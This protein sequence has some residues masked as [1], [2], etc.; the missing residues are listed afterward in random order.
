VIRDSTLA[1]SGVPAVAAAIVTRDSV[2]ALHVAGVRRRGNPTPVTLDDR[3]HIGSNTKAFTA[4][5]MGLLVDEGRVAWATTLA[6]LFPELAATM[7]PEYR[8]VTVRDLLTH[9]GGLVRDARDAPENEPGRAAAA[10]A[11]GDHQ[12][13]LRPAREPRQGRPAGGARAPSPFARVTAMDIDNPPLADPAGRLNLSIREWARWAQAVLR[14]AS[15]G[16]SPWTPTTT[17]ALF[18]P[19]VAT[20]S[21]AMGWQALRRPWAQPGGRILVHDGSN[22][23]FLSVAVLAPE[24]G[25]AVLVV[26]NQGGSGG[27]KVIPGLANRLI[28]LV[29]NGQQLH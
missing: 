25:F 21:M 8:A 18:T 6:E 10:R 27:D 2:V 23:L 14:A 29:T 7:R 13:R 16:A 28:R 22:R 26:T 1:A 3:F 15:G 11:A 9:H 5:L 24:A 4:G 17:G 19:P 20:D 12:H